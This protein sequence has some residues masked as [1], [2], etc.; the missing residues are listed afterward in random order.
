MIDQQTRQRIID[1]AQ[2]LDVVSDFVSLRRQGISYVG[3]CPFHSDRHPSF[4]VT[5]SKNI[6]KCFS[7]GEGGTPLNFIMKHEQLSYTEALKYLAKK[8]NIEVVEREETEEEKQRN[9]E[10]ESLFIVNDFAAKFFQQQLTETE[11]GRSIG[12]SYFRERGIRPETIEKF[13][14]GYSPEDKSSAHRRR[15]QATASSASST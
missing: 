9:N 1:T 6:C 5:P 13:G 11:E 15:R 3:L 14:L 7:C 2:I 10:R 12:L 8:Y 4:Y